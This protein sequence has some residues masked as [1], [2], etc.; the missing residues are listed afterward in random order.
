MDDDGFFIP[1][2]KSRACICNFFHKKD[3]VPVVIPVLFMLNLHKLRFMRFMEIRE[4][5]FMHGK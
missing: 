4:I 5:T 1:L 2:E 3:V